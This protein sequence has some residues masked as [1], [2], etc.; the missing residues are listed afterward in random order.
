M[1]FSNSCYVIVA[2]FV[3]IELTF[4]LYKIHTHITNGSIR[5]SF[6]KKEEEIVFFIEN[7]RNEP[8][9]LVR[10]IIIS[11]KNRLIVACDWQL[12]PQTCKVEAAPERATRIDNH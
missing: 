5:G 1:F 2:L 10:F 9:L 6:M 7:L 12:A 8:L 4:L 11:C 3:N